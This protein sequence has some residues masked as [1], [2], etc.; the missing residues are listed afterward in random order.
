MQKYFFFLFCCFAAWRTTAQSTPIFTKVTTGPVVTTPGDSRSVNWIDVDNDGDLDLFIT[1]G[2]QGGQNNMLYLNSGT[3]TF[4][5]VTNDPIVRD[6]T[7]SDG[8]TFADYDNDGDADCF[9]ANW[10]NINNLLYKNNGNGTFE[11]VTTENVAKDMGYSETGA[12]GD[13]DNDGW[14]DLYVSNSDGN[15]RNF[16]YRN[17]RNGS[18]EKIS[19]GAPVTDVFASRTVN[20]VDINNDDWP[21][22]FVTNEN[23]Q[24]ENLYR[25]NGNG[26]F[27]KLA[28]AP[29]LT[30]Q[31]KTMSSSWGDY[32][33]DGDLDVFLANDQ[34]N[35]ALFRNEGN[36][37][38]TKIANSPVVSA[39]G[40]S[41]GSQW[42]DVDNDADLDLFVT[43]AFWG[44]PWKNFLFLNNG[45]GTFTQNETEIVSTELGWSYGCA[46]GDMDNDG[47]LDLAVATCHNTNQTDYLYQNRSAEGPN[48]WSVIELKGIK[49][50]R[51]AIGAK[52]WLKA[53]VQGKSVTQFREIS[54]Q[55]GHCGQ[56]QLAAHFG[57]ADASSIEQVIVQWPAGGR[58]TITRLEVRKKYI[59]T[60]NQG[61]SA[62]D[63]P[64]INISGLQVSP[65]PVSDS[66]QAIW[67]QRKSASINIQIID[68]QG[69]V[70]YK[71]T[72]KTPSGQN[73]W[74][75][76]QEQN[77]PSG[78][79]FL[80]LND[81]HQSVSTAIIVR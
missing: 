10:Y 66:V 31:G 21:D 15:F 70:A 48:A 64:V 63:A 6:G 65:N 44:G 35:D 24:N 26:T 38:F 13:Y 36:F 72:I 67:L 60:E 42:A 57:L 80:Q 5:A 51:S 16:L 41:F 9:V 28:N 23:N 8:A 12:W 47:D 14:L 69:V 20:W 77:I 56:N 81:G 7:P 46:F 40:N 79:Y 55:S 11:Q 71:T 39:G 19:T 29:L 32:D 62:T 75:W 52:V 1:N 49:S 78:T 17:L 59:I 43:N 34:T 18:F 73:T 37:T 68:S 2:L 30:A 22:L 4:T 3:G 54:T 27:T 58:D 45:N 50:N 53:T 61:L 25:N 33:N 76:K 74:N